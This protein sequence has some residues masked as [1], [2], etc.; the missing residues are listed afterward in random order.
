MHNY[1]DKERE[2]EE[3]NRR[4]N[5]N[6]KTVKIGWLLISIERMHK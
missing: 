6:N 4:K 1:T 2:T 3:K 5:R